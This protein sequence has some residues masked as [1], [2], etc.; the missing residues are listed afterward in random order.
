MEDYVAGP[1]ADAPD[2]SVFYKSTGKHHSRV[3]TDVTVTRQREFARHEVDA[4]FDLAEVGG[5]RQGFVN[6][7]YRRYKTTSSGYKT[8]HTGLF[9]S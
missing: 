7:N 2:V 6:I 1:G 4:V 8:H 5:R 9:D 3:G